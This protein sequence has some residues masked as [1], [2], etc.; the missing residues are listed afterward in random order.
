MQNHTKA[1]NPNQPKTHEQTNRRKPQQRTQAVRPWASRPL[2]LT[3]EAALDQLAQRQSSSK[4]AKPTEAPKTQP[5]DDRQQN[6]TNPNPKPKQTKPKPR[7]NTPHSPQIAEALYAGANFRS[8]MPR[9]R[10][11][12]FSPCQD[13]STYAGGP[14]LDGWVPRR[15]AYL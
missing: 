7:T 13:R 8:A 9:I 2:P 15:K 10:Q 5:N 1:I 3:R 12:I 6:P 4:R 14:L 11:W